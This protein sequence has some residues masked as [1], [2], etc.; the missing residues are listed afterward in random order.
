MTKT[1]WKEAQECLSCGRKS[2]TISLYVSYHPKLAQI[3]AGHCPRC[4]GTEKLKQDVLAAAQRGHI[5]FR[6]DAERDQRT[7]LD[8]LK[9][10]MPIVEVAL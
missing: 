7:F 3:V 9:C 4:E 6:K 5:F 8:F 10:G 1:E 2:R